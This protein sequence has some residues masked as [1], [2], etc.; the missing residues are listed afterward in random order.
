MENIGT[1]GGGYFCVNRPHNLTLTTYTE[2][3][4]IEKPAIQLMQ[5]ELGWDAVNAYD[6]W[7]GGVSS[8]G[9]EGKRDVVLVSRLRSRLFPA[10]PSPNVR[11]HDT[12]VSPFILPENGI[13][14][15]GIC[16]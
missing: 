8:L 5:H 2:D 15:L 13:E 16:F 10:T 4:L 1:F 9:R 11:I 3:H 6:E 14:L 7:A 12:S